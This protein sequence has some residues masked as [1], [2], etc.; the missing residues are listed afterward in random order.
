MIAWS[1]MK[2]SIDF[3]FLKMKQLT[4]FSFKY[5]RWCIQ[6]QQSFFFDINLN[7]ENIKWWK[8]CWISISWSQRTCCI[9][10]ICRI[11][12]AS[13]VER[14]FLLK[15]SWS[16]S[17]YAILT[18]CSMINSNVWTY[19]WSECSASCVYYTLA[20]KESLR[21]KEISSIF[22]SWY[23][24]NFNIDISKIKIWCHF[25][26]MIDWLFKFDVLQLIAAWVSSYLLQICWYMQ[27]K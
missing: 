6:H 5:D 1:N 7:D 25:L 14:R 13:F 20:S 4:D 26:L 12:E 17:W 27:L 18:L 11:F 16:R 3:Q 19:L 22:M 9:K 23:E 24:K 2:Y 8:I 15:I 10:S 21:A